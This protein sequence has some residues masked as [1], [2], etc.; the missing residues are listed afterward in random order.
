MYREEQRRSP[1]QAG[2]PGRTRSVPDAT[3]VLVLCYD[4]PQNP[5]SGGAPRY[6]FEMARRLVAAGY[7]VTWLSARFPGAPIQEDLDGVKIVRAGSEPTTFLHAM[8]RVVGRYRDAVIFESI[9]GIPYFTPL[10]THQPTLS[11]VHHVIP[12]E[13]FVRKVG[14]LGLLLEFVQNRISPRLYRDRPVITNSRSTEAELRTLGFRS[15][16]VVRSGVDLPTKAELG[17]NVKENLAVIT[18]PLRPWKRVEHGLAAFA[19]LPTDWRL[20][21]IGPFENATYRGR[22]L[23]EAARLGIAGRTV[24]TDRVPEPI[25]RGFYRR[26]KVALVTSEKEGWGLSA[27][28]P[29]T[30]GCAVVGYD[31]AGIRDSVGNGQTGVLVPSGDLGALRQALVDLAADTRRFERLAEA[32]RNRFIDYTWDNVFSDFYGA[33]HEATVRR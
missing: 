17:G 24:F 5:K 21:V 23:E 3:H 32:A 25:K 33:F 20:A 26:A 14:G 18:G 11:M 12:R 30:F 13:T 28:E 22:L 16:R 2:R 9:S 8:A 6:C 27:V 31:V 19:G 10:L 29:Q 15:I 4:D 7:R 1:S